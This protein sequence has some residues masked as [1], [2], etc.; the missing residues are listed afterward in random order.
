MLEKPNFKPQNKTEGK[1][2]LNEGIKPIY[3]SLMSTFE[4]NFIDPHTGTEVFY[5]KDDI[6][7]F[8][9]QF[10]KD[11]KVSNVSWLDGVNDMASKNFLNAGH[12][13]YVISTVDNSNKFSEG[14]FMCT[15]LLAVGVDKETGK[16]ISLL[17]H[18]YPIIFSNP[19]KR[20]KFIKDL[21]SR[22]QD[23]KNRSV[24]GS[25]DAVAFGGSYREDQEADNYPIML[26]YYP[27]S[28]NL[29]ADGV[30]NI[31]GF[32]PVVINGPKLKRIL[33][34]E[35][36]SDSVYFDNKNRRLYFVR[37]EINQPAPGRTSGDFPV[38][39]LEDRKKDW[40]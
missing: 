40:K 32:D 35:Q 17:T 20:N 18:Q 3:V 15:G 14:F 26:K 30:R 6:D 12:Q 2:H 34:G 25:V 4:D 1:S 27:D 24:E 31:L 10:R 38:G 16:N 29:S 8:I 28:V 11:S 9:Y 33:N 21:N 39:E 22:L 23:L 36:I 5:S 7:D 37:G 19:E 13:S